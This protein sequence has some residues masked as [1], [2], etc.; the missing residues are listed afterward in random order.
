MAKDPTQELKPMSLR[1]FV[2]LGF[3]QEANR[4]FFHPLG[5]ALYAMWSEDKPR[6]H[7]NPPTMLGIFDL[8]D[9]PDGV[10]FGHFS[11]EDIER[12]KFVEAHKQA[13]IRARQA[14]FD[15]E[16]IQPLKVG[17]FS[18]NRK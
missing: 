8:R 5:I 15:G 10:V 18:L 2:D 4:Q 17:I 14:L 6:E 3:L 7:G 13:R 11:E 12:G 1:D 16:S 9:D